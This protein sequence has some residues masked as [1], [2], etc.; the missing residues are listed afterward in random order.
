[1]HTLKFL[2]LMLFTSTAIAW[3]PTK[4]VTVVFPN[5][6]GAGNEISFR[7][8]ADIVERKTGVKFNSEYRPGAGRGRPHQ[9]CRTARAADR[10]GG[11]RTAPADRPECH[12]QGPAE[13][14][15]RRDFRHGPRRTRGRLDRLDAK[16]VLNGSQ[17]TVPIFATSTT[18]LC[19]SA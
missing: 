13:E 9:A 8:V 17:G 15:P 4:P 12:G 11:V 10:G 3:Q 5:G 14:P 7:I 2:A 6:P 18:L 19:E 1:M 16:R